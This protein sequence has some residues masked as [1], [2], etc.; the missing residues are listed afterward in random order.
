MSL[1]TTACFTGGMR[2]QT[3]RPRLVKGDRALPLAPVPLLDNDISEAKL[4]ELQL[5]R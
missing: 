1:A 5:L 3:G 2:A 4:Q